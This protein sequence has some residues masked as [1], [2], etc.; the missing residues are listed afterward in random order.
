MWLKPAF[1][2]ADARR[3]L[4]EALWDA[5]KNHD[6]QPVIVIDERYLLS[7]AMVEKIRLLTNLQMDAAPPMALIL[8]GQTELRHR[9]QLQ[10]FEAIAQRVN[11]R[12]HLSG[13]SAQE[14]KAYIHHLSLGFSK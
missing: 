12:F 13:L 1:Y 7:T 4:T 8:V 9:L 3:Q 11:L 14:T 5:Y 2:A 6:K 10:T